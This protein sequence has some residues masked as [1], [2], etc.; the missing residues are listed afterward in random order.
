GEV[1]FG[2]CY[3]TVDRERQAKAASANHNRIYLCGHEEG[4]EP[5]G[6]DSLR[7]TFADAGVERTYIWLSPGP[8]MDEVRAWLAQRG[9]KRV[10]W[11]TYPVLRR[12][13]EGAPSFSTDLQIR[14]VGQREVAAA[15]AAMGEA[16]WPDYARSIGKDGLVH[17]MA[18][19][20]ARPVAIGM[21]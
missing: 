14:E 15:K 12:S 5:E 11:T 20:G 6:L 3:V 7:G 2:A 17:F 18:F 4:L 1:P 16:M 10:R 13:T 9:C 19:D 21:L 8:D